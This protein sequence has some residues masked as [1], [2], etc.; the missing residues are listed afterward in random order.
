MMGG[1]IL[2]SIVLSK[3]SRYFGEMKRQVY[4]PE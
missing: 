1:F 3:A 4:I 2:G